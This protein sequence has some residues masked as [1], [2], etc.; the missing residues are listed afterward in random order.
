MGRVIKFFKEYAVPLT[1][2]VT[3]M[4][5]LVLLLMLRIQENVALK[6]FTSTNPLVRNTDG[7]LISGDQLAALN[8]DTNNSQSSGSNNTNQNSSSPS[9]SPSPSTNPSTSPSTNPTT[10]PPPP[11]TSGG[12]TTPTTPPPPPPSTPGE[13]RTEITRLSHFGFIMPDTTGGCSIMHN[14]E[15]EIT[16]YDGPG[17]VTYRWVRS[18]NYSSPVQSYGAPTGQSTQ[19]VNHQ[20]PIYT[21]S[22]NSNQQYWVELRTLTPTAATRRVDFQH[23]CSGG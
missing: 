15:G 12:G 19:Y 4:V 18:D 21:T 8:I 22:G 5:V 16:A 1:G 14:I 17:L 6:N 20:W 11:P 2:T 3:L 7:S 10:P 13:F 23:S 9:T